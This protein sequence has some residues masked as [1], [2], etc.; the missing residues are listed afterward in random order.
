MMIEVFCKVQFEAFHHWPEAPDEV[1]FLRDMHRHIFHVV[2]YKAVEHSDR[3]IE[4]I[5]L[6]RKVDKYLKRKYKSGRFSCEDIAL[7]LMSKFGLSKCEVSED[8]E[9]GSIVTR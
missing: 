9:N 5:L 8:G 6:K 1:S 2:A 3:D 4:F 7:D